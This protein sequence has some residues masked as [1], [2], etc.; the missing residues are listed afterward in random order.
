MEDLAKAGI[1]I[2]VVVMIAIAA[3]A[4]FGG[5]FKSPE[6]TCALQ[7]AIYDPIKDICVPASGVGQ[8]CFPFV[9]SGQCQYGLICGW[10]LF[11]PLALFREC[12]GTLQYPGG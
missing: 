9:S 5:M 10:N 11:N 4:I 12:Q 2:A 7:G 6:E 1:V 3:Y 8:S